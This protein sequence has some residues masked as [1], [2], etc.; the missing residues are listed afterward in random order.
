MRCRRVF[1]YARNRE[2][3][4]E[5]EAAQ[6]E[7]DFWNDQDRSQRLVREMKAAKGVV[8]PITRLQDIFEE[9]EVLEEMA[10]EAGEED[11]VADAGDDRG[12]AAGRV[13][14]AEGVAA[15]GGRGR[16]RRRSVNEQD[17][18]LLAQIRFG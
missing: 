17:S 5:I 15:A 7:P 9:I 16:G 13:G 10:S 6:V 11:L 4:G 14:P 12:R 18:C 2:R 8:D 1:D 3:I